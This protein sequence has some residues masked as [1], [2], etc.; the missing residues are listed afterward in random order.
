MAKVV[1]GGSGD[2]SDA[3]L[4]AAELVSLPAEVTTLLDD[5]G[6]AIVACRN[7]V[8]DFA[9]RLKGV[10]PTNWREDQTWDI[11][12]GAY[13]PTEKAIV[14]ATVERHGRRIVPLTNDAHGS[15]SLAVH[16]A[17]HG[18]DYNHGKRPSE[19]QRFRAC[20]LADY[21]LLKVNYFR[22]PATGPEESYAESGARTY[23]LSQKSIN[24]WPHLR[25]YWLRPG[26]PFAGPA[27]LEMPVG[28]GEAPI[29]I[30]Y[31][32]ADGTVHLLLTATS[33]EGDHGHAPIEL[34]SEA[35]DRSPQWMEK[36]PT[37]V[38]E[39]FDVYSLEGLDF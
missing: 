26:V 20:W 16:E 24:E 9:P 12:P 2:D 29:G 13:L 39:P 8:V 7:S 30:G 31:R 27:P 3:E 21:G 23:G 37:N 38:G 17:L 19:Q 25:D 34:R 5:E 15:A 35:I 1:P 28:G 6:V 22:D 18:F 14:V 36:T 32:L 4:V 11:V 10:R 33:A